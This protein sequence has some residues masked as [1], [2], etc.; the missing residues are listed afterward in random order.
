MTKDPD[1]LV[2]R[3]LLLMA[4]AIG[5]FVGGLV[6]SGATIFSTGAD[7]TRQPGRVGPGEQLPAG[8]LGESP[9]GRDSAV[10]DERNGRPE[11]AGGTAQ[12]GLAVG[13]LQWE[14]PD[15]AAGYTPGHALAAPMVSPGALNWSAVHARG[16]G[17]VGPD[18]PL[19]MPG[20]AA[21]AGVGYSRF[22]QV[23]LEPVLVTRSLN[24]GR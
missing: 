9:S 19:Q 10:R 24:A 15:Y 12:S 21:D 6:V 22:H 5:L 17:T 23:E 4:A 18:H 8:A 14:R 20:A 7:E 1:K 11:F 2:Q 16:T 13:A 3:Q